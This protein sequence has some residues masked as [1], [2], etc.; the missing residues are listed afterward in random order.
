LL[1]FSCLMWLRP[2][3][4]KMGVVTVTMSR[5]TNT[6][7][8]VT[9][10]TAL[11]D[12]RPDCLEGYEC[13][14]K[15]SYEDDSYYGECSELSYQSPRSGEITESG[16]YCAIPFSYNGEQYWSCTT[17]DSENNKPWCATEVDETGEVVRGRWED[18][19]VTGNP[20]PLQKGCQFPF[21]FRGRTYN[22]CADWTAGGQPAGTT[23][24]STKVDTNR[25]HLKG[26]YMF[27]PSSPGASESCQFPF[28]YKGTTYNSCVAWTAGGQP[29][30]SSW[31]STKVDTNREHV[32][33]YYKF[34]QDGL[35]GK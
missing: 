4:T 32:K 28:I 13:E 5:D 9:G 11:K 15:Y 29:A 19:E 35:P 3:V 1:L 14:C 24:C 8:D 2:G 34:C 7:R 31:C 21:I 16:N 18:C 17:T 30:G 33:G 22:S 27:C 26:F 12:M 10:Q 25:E 23:W 6:L 20:G